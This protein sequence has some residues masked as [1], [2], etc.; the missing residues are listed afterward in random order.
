MLNQ[1]MLMDQLIK[2][3]VSL[4]TNSDFVQLMELI[5][6][7]SVAH[8]SGIDALFQLMTAIQQYLNPEQRQTDPSAPTPLY[9]EKSQESP[10]PRSR[11]P[12][13]TRDGQLEIEIAEVQGPTF[14]SDDGNGTSLDSDQQADVVATPGLKLAL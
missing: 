13:R 10:R 12:G 4:P 1:T 11:T 8:S 7:H 2:I 3:L 9:S 6:G 14:R 5:R